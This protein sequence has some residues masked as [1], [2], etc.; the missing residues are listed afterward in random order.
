VIASDGILHPAT[1]VSKIVAPNGKV[2][3][4]TPTSGRRILSAQ[5]ARSETQMLTGVLKN[6]TASG[7]SIDR[8]AAGKTGTTD[9]NQDAWFIGYT[10]Q[11]TTAVW[12]GDPNAETPMTSVGGI[13]V[14]GATYPADIWAAFMKAAHKDLPVVKLIPPNE[15]KW[16]EQ[17]QIDELGRGYNSY[18]S[19]SSNYTAPTTPATVPVTA[20]AAPPPTTPP[21]VSPTTSPPATL[22]NHP[23]PTAPGKNPPPGGQGQ[24]P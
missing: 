9:Q 4:E 19:Y 14:F 21:I 1:F 8:P 20:P 16:P 22:P 23:P 18:R 10:P 13:S 7:L 24:N 15:A 11:I 3:Y 17:Q 5:V 2:L 12:M 6:G